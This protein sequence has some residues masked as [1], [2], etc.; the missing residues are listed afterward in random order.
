M[1]LK[2]TSYNLHGWN[3]GANFLKV[4]R[5]CTDVIMIQEHWLYPSTLSRLEDNNNAYTVFAISA[6]NNDKIRSGRPYRGRFS[7]YGTQ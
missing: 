1:T 3:N 2:L 6:M 7:I 5:N 4:L